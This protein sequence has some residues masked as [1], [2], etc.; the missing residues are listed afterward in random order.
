MNWLDLPPSARFL[1]AE[2]QRDFGNSAAIKPPSQ[3]GA[4]PLAVLL[5]FGRA[6]AAGTMR[7]A[8]FS[9]NEFRVQATVS[10]PRGNVPKT[11]AGEKLDVGVKENQGDG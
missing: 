1:L 6:T 3:H 9:V 8:S 11:A 10:R 2:R 7:L 5:L 4:A